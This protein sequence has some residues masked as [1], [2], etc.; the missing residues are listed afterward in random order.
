MTNRSPSAPFYHSLLDYQS[1]LGLLFILGPL[2]LGYSHI[3]GLFVLGPPEILG[4]SL[5]LGVYNPV[6]V[7]LSPSYLSIILIT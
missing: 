4:L 5:L 6:F 1:S 7:I 2:V 3:L